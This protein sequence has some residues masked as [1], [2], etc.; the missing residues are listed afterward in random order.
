L[1][2]RSASAFGP[3]FPA[4]IL[5]AAALVLLGGCGSLFR[6]SPPP[7][8]PFQRLYYDASRVLDVAEPDPAFYRERARLEVAGRELDEVLTALIVDPSRKDHVRAN[9]VTLLADREGFNAVGVLRRQ[10]VSATADPVREAAAVGLRRFA[11]DSAGARNALRAALVDPVWRVRL[12]ALQGLDVEDARAVRAL[13]EREDD[14]RVQV[15]ARQLLT[16][17]EARGAPLM[18]GERG[19]LRTSGG[20]TVPRLVFQPAAGEGPEGVRHG[21]LWVE[22][23][24]SNELV[25]LAQE[26]EVVGDVVPAFFDPQRRAVVFEAGRQI[27]IR[28]LQ[29][30]ETR[31][32]AAGVAPR[33]IPFTDRFVFVREASRTPA[34]GGATELE[35]EVMR[36]S[37]TGGDAQ[38]VARLR[39]RARPQWFGGAS[40]V[41]TMVVGERRE[42]FVL[43]GPG[44]EPIVLETP[45]EAPPPP[46]R[47]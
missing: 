15:V 28:D 1:T 22:L 36:A 16:L 9:A 39:T 10:L 29:S 32:I 18:R 41:R 11:A 30:G 31:T 38:V 33:P 42:G 35:Y 23:P 45:A 37:F 7:G 4:R 8:Y 34:G 46:P 13:L 6:R 2:T 40:P 17:F 27:Q 21:A 47:P 43:R 3:R 25:P 12:A 24:G 26:V 44:I 19:D 5:A 20:D 14:A